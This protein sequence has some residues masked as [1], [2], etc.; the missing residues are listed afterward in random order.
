MS[1]N[2]YLLLLAEH[3]GRVNHDTLSGEGPERVVLHAPYHVPL[4]W[5][6]LFSERNLHADTEDAFRASEMSTSCSLISCTAGIGEAVALMHAR[7]SFLSALY[8]V[9]GDL[10]HHIDLFGRYLAS[11][12][13]GVVGLD[14]TELAANG[15]NPSALELRR[16]LSRLDLGDP[17]VREQLDAWS[18]LQPGVRLITL[19]QGRGC[20]AEEMH[21]YFRVM[22]SG[23]SG[24]A[25]WD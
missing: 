3:K 24:D 11:L 8:A 23:Y 7:L 5:I 12:G 25:P 1:D 17:G 18:T 16:L 20:S 4:L 15:G 19:E 10:T 9:E 21:N 13:D 6:A 14:I 22:G 2:A